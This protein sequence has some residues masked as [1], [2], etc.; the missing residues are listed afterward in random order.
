MQCTAV[1]IAGLRRHNTTHHGGCLR[2]CWF[3]SRCGAGGSR[4]YFF[5]LFCLGF[6]A[7][8]LPLSFLPMTPPSAQS[9]PS[10]ERN[11]VLLKSF[12]VAASCAPHTEFPLSFCFRLANAAFSASSC[13]GETLIGRPLKSR[14]LST[15]I[16]DRNE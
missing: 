1:C 7:S 11:C 12:V 9:S 6:L 8:R 14:S 16:S 4:S 10:Q 2:D 5:G 3:P 13:F 15:G